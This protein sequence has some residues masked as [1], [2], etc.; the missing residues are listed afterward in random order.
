[1]RH[2]SERDLKWALLDDDVGRLL[3]RRGEGTVLRRTR[4]EVRQV[5][6]EMGQYGAKPVKV[7]VK[8]EVV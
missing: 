5:R 2:F 6:D 8:Y 1:M 7:L 3:G 4:K